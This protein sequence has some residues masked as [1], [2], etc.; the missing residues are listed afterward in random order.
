MVIG[1]EKEIFSLHFAIKYFG[2]LQINSEYVTNFS[3][4]SPAAWG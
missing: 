2:L 4:L 3:P 1:F